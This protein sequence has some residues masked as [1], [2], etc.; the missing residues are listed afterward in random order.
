MPTPGRLRLR[1]AAPDLY[2]RVV[3]DDKADDE[4]IAALEVREGILEVARGFIS[5]KL[6]VLV[7]WVLTRDARR[8]GMQRGQH[9]R[10][11]CLGGQFGGVRGACGQSRHENR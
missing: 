10:M 5:G 11:H 9:Y 8:Q 7:V 2:A 4:A 3:D 6:R 1:E